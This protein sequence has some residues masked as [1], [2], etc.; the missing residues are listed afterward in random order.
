MNI[1]GEKKIHK[2][3]RID[4][5]LAELVFIWLRILKN[6]IWN[7]SSDIKETFKDAD[8]ITKNIYVFNLKSFR[9]LCIVDF[10][11]EDVDIL[12]FGNHDD[13]TR[14]FNSKTKILKFVQD[15]GYNV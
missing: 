3:I 7:S 1:N 2:T 12:W 8:T 15:N 13:Y 4:R 6:V 14:K 11:D 5:N 10:I 9:F